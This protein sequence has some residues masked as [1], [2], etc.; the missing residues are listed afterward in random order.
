VELVPLYV[1]IAWIG[2]NLSSLYILLIGTPEGRNH[3][4]TK[5]I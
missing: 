1:F 2:I 5:R 3:L 4:G